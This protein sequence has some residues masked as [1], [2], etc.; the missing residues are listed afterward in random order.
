[1]KSATNKQPG[2]H[3]G[4]TRRGAVIILIALLLIP[5]MGSVALVV[6]IASMYVVQA[7]LQTAAD[8]AALAAAGEMSGA[9]ADV[10]L[11]MAREGAKLYA[12]EHLSFAMQGGLQLDDADIEFG[13]AQ[14]D[15][16]TGAWRFQLDET[17]PAP[18]A[19]RVTVRRDGETNPLVPLFFAHVLGFGDQHMSATSASMINPRD[20]ALVIDLSGSMSDDSELKNK[21]DVQINL[22]D[23]WVT[24]DGPAGSPETKFIDGKGTFIKDYELRGP[25]ESVYASRTGQTFG[26]M[27]DWGTSIY[28]GNYSDNAIAADPG[29]YYL[30]ERS[31]TPSNGWASTLRSGQYSW[32]VTS[33]SNPYSLKSRNYSQAEINALLKRPSSNENNTTYRNRAK[34]VLGLS[35]WNDN[36][37]DKR[38]D[39]NE[40]VDIVDESYSIGANWDNWINDMRSNTGLGGADSTFRYRLGLKTYINWLMVRSY[41][42]DYNAGGVGRTPSLQF[43]PI[44]PLQ[45]VKDAVHGFT[46][47]L[48]SVDSNDKV[49]LV[50][51]GSRGSV[52]PFS[53]TNGLTNDFD[54][55]SD[56]PYPHQ[57]GEQGA[58]TN[59]ADGIVRGYRMVYGAGSREYAH[60]VI[61]FMSDGYANYSN[62]FSFETD[63]EDPNVQDQLSQIS[64]MEDFDDLVGFPAGSVRYDTNEARAETLGIANMMASNLLGT[65]PAEFNVVG[66][67][68]HADIHNLLQPLAEASGGDA[69]R[70]LPDVNDPQAM[71]RILK[72]IYE[73][74]GG[75]RPIALIKP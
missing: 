7:E 11:Q 44:E 54:A 6:D 41:S 59:T 71:Q 57:P 66:V 22:R 3:P 75:R 9:T 14:Q 16:D 74:I 51:Y 24:L 29:L 31:K 73:R 63:L 23:I 1:M 64:S 30:P 38:I 72:E 60:K 37:H 18:F 12:A 68:A 40:V 27:A 2:D 67:G 15:E 13:V 5:I 33:Q 62:G 42:K 4:K 34:V 47:Y 20:I 8:A 56:L 43:T 65:G 45:A 46:D 70:A 61:V 21:D 55:V 36:D 53:Q 49:G 48:K 19:V 69:Y 39:N 58:Y 17:C 26:S 35:N 50:V 52:D 28:R 25:G 32:L 10:Y